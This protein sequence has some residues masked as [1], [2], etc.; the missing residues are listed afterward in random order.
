MAATIRPVVNCKRMAKLR[1]TLGVLD[2]TVFEVGCP[3]TIATP[4]VFELPQG[5]REDSE[6]SREKL[7][8]TVNI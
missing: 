2:N 6:Y 8:R 4:S 5:Q 7:E 1:L 3:A